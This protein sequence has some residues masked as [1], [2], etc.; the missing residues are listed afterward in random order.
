ML[1]LVSSNIKFSFRALGISP[2]GVLVVVAV[3]DAFFLGDEL[4]DSV[5]PR[6]IDSDNA[7]FG[8]SCADMGAV[9]GEGTTFDERVPPGA[10]CGAGGFE[11]DDIFVLD[12]V[13]WRKD[14]DS[15]VCRRDAGRNPIRA[16]THVFAVDPI[17]DALG[18]ED[19]ALDELVASLGCG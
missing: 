8:G 13:D 9:I 15:E 18:F 2:L 4:A 14:I 11:G 1:S 10:F 16:E 17:V 7:V 5:P 6:E 3:G 19:F 12:V